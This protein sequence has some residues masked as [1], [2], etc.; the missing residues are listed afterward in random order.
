MF[1]MHTISVENWSQ[2]SSMQL[3]P[4][5]TAHEMINQYMVSE[6][7]KTFH[8]HAISDDTKL[9]LCS[10]SGTCIG[11][12]PC[13]SSQTEGGILLRSER[14]LK[15]RNE[16]IFTIRFDIMILIISTTFVC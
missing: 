14:C 1:P 16:H 6:N 3:S 12:W 13:R 8:K 4:C 2:I 15:T 9:I 7:F 5:K 10:F 11:Q